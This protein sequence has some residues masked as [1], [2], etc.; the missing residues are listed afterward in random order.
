MIKIMEIESIIRVIESYGSNILGFFIL[1]RDF[2]FSMNENFFF[3]NISSIVFD[4]ARLSFKF[5]ILLLSL[6]SL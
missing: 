4:F 2:I 5:T 6:P 1:K 3:A